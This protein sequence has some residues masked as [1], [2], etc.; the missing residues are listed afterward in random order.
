MFETFDSFQFIFGNSI[1]D[2]LDD[3]GVNAPEPG[4][5]GASTVE[6]VLDIS[7]NV[8]DQVEVTIIDSTSGDVF[9]A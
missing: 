5:G 7:D 1:I 3:F 9:A 2:V 4:D 6:P 8:E